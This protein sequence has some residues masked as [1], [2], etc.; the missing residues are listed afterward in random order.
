MSRYRDVEEASGVPFYAEVGHLAVGV[1]GGPYITTVRDNAK[2]DH[3]EHTRL[4]RYTVQ[5]T[6]PFFFF[7]FFCLAMRIG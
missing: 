1:R 3:V 4:E 7:F 2:K 6:S 5:L